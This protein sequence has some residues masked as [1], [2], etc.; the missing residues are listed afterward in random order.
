MVRVMKYAAASGSST[1]L[2]VGVPA[3][4]I[5][6]TYSP[7]AKPGLAG[8][9]SSFASLSANEPPPVGGLPGTVAAAFADTEPAVFG[10]GLVAAGAGTL[11]MVM[12]DLPA[13]FACANA[14]PANA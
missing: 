13:P 6:R 9:P 5:S 7:S 11:T 12:L 4:S 3:D 2:P 8:S 14:F 10:V 1:T